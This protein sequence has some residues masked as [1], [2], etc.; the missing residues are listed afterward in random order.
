M[1]TVN[2][3]RELSVSAIMSQAWNLT[4][5]HFPIFLLLMILYG[6]I[7]NFPNSI[8]YS[9]YFSSMLDGNALLTKEEWL[10]TMVERN[11]FEL[12]RLLGYMSLAG[13]ICGFINVYLTL[14]TFRL[15]MDAVEGRKVDLTASLKGACRGYWFY[16][17]CYLL[18]MIA[19]S[20][21]LLLCIIPGIFLG[22]R[23][24]FVP[25]MAA[26][27]PEYTCGEVFSKSWNMTK[28]HFW[29]LFLLGIVVCLINLLG[30]LVCCVGIFVTS[31]INCFV[32]ALAYKQLLPES[33][34]FANEASAPITSVE[35]TGRTQKP[36]SEG[37]YNKSEKE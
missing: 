27:H 25:L 21:G 5:K 37:N 24:M 9:S 22:V 14:A 30:L 16:L 20:C 36:F 17:G 7:S 6:V 4:K 10:N 18:C 34:D 2:T 33:D 32:Y 31:I 1:E 15:L 13:I 29:D 11:P 3:F 19:V 8:Y 12:L 35:D 23:L 26:H 28:D